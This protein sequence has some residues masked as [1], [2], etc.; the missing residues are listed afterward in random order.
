MNT[1]ELFKRP[2]MFSSESDVSR[3][4]R[5]PPPGN[6]VPIAGKHRPGFLQI[7]RFSYSR[8]RF[9]RMLNTR[10]VLLMGLRTRP[11]RNLP[12]QEP[13]TPGMTNGENSD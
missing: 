6:C 5:H 4:Y 10:L 13:C 9:A 12:L 1:A 8:G 2:Y 11:R 7:L 3:K